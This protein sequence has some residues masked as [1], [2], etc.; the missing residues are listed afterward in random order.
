FPEYMKTVKLN[1]P[2]SNNQ[3]PDVLDEILWNLR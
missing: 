1:I 3:L 2:E